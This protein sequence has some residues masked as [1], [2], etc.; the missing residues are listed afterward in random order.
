MINAPTSDDPN[1]QI[2]GLP[3]FGV[4]SGYGLPLNFG[5]PQASPLGAFTDD[6]YLADD[7]TLRAQIGQQYT[8]ILQQL[9]YMDP[10]TGNVIPGTV[11]QDANIQLGSYLNDLYNE[12]Q[13]NVQNAQQGGT[14]FSGIRAQ[15]LAQAQNPTQ[16]GI[17]Q[18]NLNTSRSLGDLYNQAQ[19]LVTNYNTQNQQN[20]ASAAARNLA[21]IQQAQLLAAA[22][23]S[24]QPTGGGGA[25]GGGAT[26][27]TGTINPSNF[28]TIPD[29]PAVTPPSSTGTSNMGQGPNYAP[30]PVAPPASYTP[31]GG[32][33]YYQSGKGTYGSK[34]LY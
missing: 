25:G 22:Q 5:F 18:L 23:Q 21:A 34:P 28:P 12:Q 14:L 30:R 17:A 26:T 9:G 10:N 3:A 33:I 27:D 32:S 8:S 2:A 16:Q 11:A 15:Q 19:N 4:P 1:L 20:L 24:A 7:S 29:T 13:S 31:S 6:Q